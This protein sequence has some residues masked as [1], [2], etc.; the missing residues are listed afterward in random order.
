MEPSCLAY[1]VVNWMDG[2]TELM[3]CLNSSLC[4]CCRMTKVSS[5]YLFHNLR[6]F[7]ADVRALSLSFFWGIIFLD[8]RIGFQKCGP[9]LA[10]QCWDY[11]SHFILHIQKGFHL[12]NDIKVQMEFIGPGHAPN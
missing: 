9:K 10:N 1:S 5:T 3:C 8:V 4:D 7:T 6:G 2:S 12:L 11:W